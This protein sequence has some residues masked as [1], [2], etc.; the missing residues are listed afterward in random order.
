[1]TW[2]LKIKLTRA[3]HP[4]CEYTWEGHKIAESLAAHISSEATNIVHYASFDPDWRTQDR[5]NEQVV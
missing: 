2:G 5:R 1:M 3:N 4:F